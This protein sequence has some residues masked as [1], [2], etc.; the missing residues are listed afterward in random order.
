MKSTTE[1]FECSTLHSPVVLDVAVP[2]A[3]RLGQDPALELG[4]EEELPLGPEETLL[5]TLGVVPHA[6]ELL[7]VTKLKREKV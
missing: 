6:Q 2:D 7:S 5:A 1:L 3:P 4:L